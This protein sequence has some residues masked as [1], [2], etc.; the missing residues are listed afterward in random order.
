M[1]LPQAVKSVTL[2]QLAGLPDPTPDALPVA[3]PDWLDP[4]VPVPEPDEAPLAL[5]LMV[6]ELVPLAVSEAADVAPVPAPE[7]LPEVEPEPPLL[8]KPVGLPPPHAATTQNPKTDERL[9]ML[10]PHQGGNEPN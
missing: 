1:P 7:P 9:S 5:P 4:D 3:V 8:F 6:P 2:V 10:P